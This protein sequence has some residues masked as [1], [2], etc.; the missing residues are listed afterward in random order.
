[1]SEKVITVAGVEA[2]VIRKKVKNSSQKIIL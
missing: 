2:T 1:M